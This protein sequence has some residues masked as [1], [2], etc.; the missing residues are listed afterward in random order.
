MSITI[1]E[2]LA[3]F[4]TGTDYSKL[5]SAVVDECKRDILDSIGCALAAKGQSKGEKGIA[6]GRR[7][8]G[9]DGLATI[10]G[11]GQRTSIFGA[12]F[13]NGELISTL[14]ADSVLVPGHVSP[15]VLP[16]A[17]A[18]GEAN[19]R[20]G[21]DLIAA[22][23][24]SHEMSYRF[25]ISMNGTREYKDG[26]AA[27]AAVVGYSSTI[28][29]ATAS[30]SKLKGLS[31]EQIANALAIA[32]AISPV[33]AHGAWLRHAPPS[34]IKYLLAG[35]LAQSALTAAEMGDVGHRGDLQLLDDAE[36]GYPRFIGTTLW[37]PEQLTTGLGDEWLFPNFLMFKPYPHCRVMHA[38]LD[39]L[40]EL[41]QKHD[42]RVDEID[43]ITAYGEG[44]AYVLPSFVFRDIREPQDAQF[45][46]AHGLAVAAHRIPPGPKWQDPKVVF[47]PSVMKLMEKV[48]LEVHPDSA[49][50]HGKNP[51]SRPSRVEIRARGQ[52]F[53]EDRMFPKGTPSSDSRSYMT[54]EELA[55]KF[56]NFV[57][58]IVAPETA[59]SV[60]DAVLN[61]EKVDDFGAVMRSAVWGK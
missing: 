5:P 21:K 8:G 2:R 58:G 50:A 24:V 4:A 53:A 54:T 35:A 48:R 12:A 60:I 29:G 31:T 26:K 3:R 61:L 30:A 34:T 23:A 39:I 40:T 49:D 10:I 46:F 11:T 13:A 9:T 59:D 38:P 17:F 15:Y 42:L 22:V 14:D 19:R 28:F 44:W 55:R 43:S 52:V 57:E 41:V 6:C 16:G 56:R 37:K 20:S 7:I 47:D 1:I 36:F 32:A 33:N 51:S 45:A 27:T 25:G 18:I